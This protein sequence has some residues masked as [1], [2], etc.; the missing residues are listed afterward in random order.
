MGSQPPVHDGGTGE[1]WSLD[2]LDE[3]EALRGEDDRSLSGATVT[4]DE[5][6]CALAEARNRFVL[7]YLL[8]VSRPVACYELVEYVVHKTEPPEGYTQ[9]EFRGRILT[10]LLDTTCPKLDDIGLVEFDE[11]NQIVSETNQTIIALP[12]L[13]LALKRADLNSS[14]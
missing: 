11:K 8:L 2:D 1:G 13:R 4:T 3:L 5:L 7:T 9:A 14:D 10:E 12:H 6:F